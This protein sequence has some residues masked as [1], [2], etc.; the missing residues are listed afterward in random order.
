MNSD[1]NSEKPTSL[2]KQ[3]VNRFETNN[4]LKEGKNRKIDW[5]SEHFVNTIQDKNHKDDL[6]K[7]RKIPFK[8]F[9]LQQVNEE[10]N[11]F[12]FRFNIQMPKNQTNK[13]YSQLKKIELTLEQ[14]KKSNQIDEASSVSG[15]SVSKSSLTTDSNTSMT[16]LDGSFK[17]KPN[18]SSKQK[19]E[20]K[21]T[22]PK[23]KNG[24]LELPY[25]L[26]NESDSEQI[27]GYYSSDFFKK[28]KEQAADE[29]TLADENDTETVI[30]AYNMS[31]SGEKK[32]ILI[33]ESS[34][35]DS[36][37]D[38]NNPNLKNKKYRSSKIL[39]N[40]ASKHVYEANDE[41]IRNQFIEKYQEDKSNN[42]FDTFNQLN[43]NQMLVEKANKE[44]N[45]FYE[46]VCSYDENKTNLI[47]ENIQVNKSEEKQE[48]KVFLLSHVDRSNSKGFDDY[49]EHLSEEDNYIKFDQNNDSKPTP[50][51]TIN[52]FKD[53]ESFDN[54]NSYNQI[55]ETSETRTNIIDI[56]KMKS[57]FYDT[58]RHEANW[59]LDKN[60]FFIDD[61][62]ETVYLT[63]CFK[64]NIETIKNGSK[65]FVIFSSGL[66]KTDQHPIC[67]QQVI[68]YS[69][70][71]FDNLSSPEEIIANIKQNIENLDTLLENNMNKYHPIEYAKENLIEK[72]SS[73]FLR[74]HSIVG[75]NRDILLG[76]EDNK[77][78]NKINWIFHNSLL[79]NLLS[80]KLIESKHKLFVI[81]IKAKEKSLRFDQIIRRSKLPCEI[82]YHKD[83][84]ENENSRIVTN[85]SFNEFS[86]E[87]EFKKENSQAIS[88]RQNFRQIDDQLKCEQKITPFSNLSV[89]VSNNVNIESNSHNTKE[90]CQLIDSNNK[91]PLDIVNSTPN[92]NIQTNFEVFDDFIK[93]NSNLKSSTKSEFQDSFQTNVTSNILDSQN[94]SKS[95][96]QQFIE[97]NLNK[98]NELGTNLNDQ[99][100]P[101][102]PNKIDTRCEKSTPTNLLSREQLNKMKKSSSTDEKTLKIQ[103]LKAMIQSNHNPCEN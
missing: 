73:T 60:W 13:K 100:S 96:D 75:V 89:H 77:N 63:E 51:V 59:S 16:Y 39:D 62:N 78:N 64:S 21:S 49:F 56:P 25:G 71:K 88:D 18:Q 22:N 19:F 27:D 14:K 10:Q 2:V 87:Q 55:Q 84:Q 95:Q 69:S 34:S 20:N 42:E 17:D 66:F 57:H 33:T 46:I 85:L 28:R 11:F 76:F 40:F 65:N 72:K 74:H 4:W 30:T 43:E 41:Q 5:K 3:L 98:E 94:K 6:S 93:K 80:K 45:I 103:N 82:Y 24:I 31:Q 81:L 67:F 61:S 97:T 29:D 35:S 52:L 9:Q 15:E 79:T 47:R 26:D 83:F 53:K 68:E 7:F 54:Q 23:D 90:V 1:E 38:S 36:L 58:S 48:N 99:K 86:S 92:E 91:L 44:G 102:N 70:I 32:S 37:F 50:K 8:K 101:L 12:N